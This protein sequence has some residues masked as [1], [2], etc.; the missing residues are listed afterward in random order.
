VGYSVD[1]LVIIYREIGKAQIW[2]SPIAFAPGNPFEFCSWES[3]DLED[4]E[5]VGSRGW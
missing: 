1:A 2:K 5:A 3:T 4:A